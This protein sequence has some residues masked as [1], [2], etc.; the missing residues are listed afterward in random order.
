MANGKGKLEQAKLL[1]ANEKEQ[2][3]AAERALKRAE[4]EKAVVGKKGWR[5]ARKEAF[6]SCHYLSK[7]EYNCR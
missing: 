4:E 5:L 6:T 7:E 2:R 1:A 3:M